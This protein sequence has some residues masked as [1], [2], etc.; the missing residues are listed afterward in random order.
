VYQGGYAA[1]VLVDLAPLSAAPAALLR[2]FALHLKNNG[3]TP[4][5]VEPF[6]TA[7]ERMDP[8]LQRPAR[9]HKL[10]KRRDPAGFALRMFVF[11]DPVPRDDAKTA[12][13][14][15]LD[16][17]LDVGL[18][19]ERPQGFVSPF[20]MG[21]VEGLFV[22]A[23]ALEAGE[24]AVM[25]LGATTVRIGQAVTSPRRYKRVLDLGCGAGT[26]A[27]VLSRNAATCVATDINP[28]AVAL[29][30]INAALNDT[31]N[32]EVRLGDKFAPVQGE[33]FD[34]IVSQPPF[35]AQPS[36]TA[37]H[38]ALYGGSRGDELAL[39]ILAATPRYLARGG[40]AVFLA[41]WPRIGDEVIEDR[42]R[43]AL[44]PAPN[45]LV[46]RCPPMEPAIAATSYAAGLH[47][48]L[49]PAFEA[50]ALARL[51]HFEAIG[52]SDLT[53]AFV[54][55]ERSQSPR[56]PGGFTASVPIVALGFA[57][58]TSARIDAVLAS[59]E[60]LRRGEAA[61]L[62]ARLRVPEGT[63]LSQ[64]QVGPGADVPS[65]ISASF[66][67]DVALRGIEIS[68]EMLF[69]VTFIHEAALVRDA[70]PRTAEAFGVG[71]DD[72][73]AKV[74]EA[75]LHGLECGLLGPV[76]AT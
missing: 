63:V 64:V 23:D 65:T 54:V 44:G 49:G 70:I 61:W 4:A 38:T 32:L 17:L 55:V 50:D 45:L 33:E 42:L 20:V 35:V 2:R 31:A 14:D 27:L 7:V 51:D 71:V 53:P 76:A 72:A 75:A 52:L 5:A 1:A 8:T 67:P 28:R 57:A 48:G 60:L 39:S 22:L 19:V 37:G 24:D 58:I 59:R 6:F 21:V 40:R 13:G 56:E 36:V 10:R 46:L 47:P 12:L 11:D 29:T 15:L 68:L 30:R 69:L 3:V 34:L 18:V 9:A 26:I 62:D 66:A 73:R 74:V 43:Q 16:P 25:G 41:D